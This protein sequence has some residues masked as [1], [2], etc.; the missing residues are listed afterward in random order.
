MLKKLLT[1]LLEPRHYWR[2]VGFSE[3]AELYANRLLRIVAVNMVSGVLGIFM[4][5]LGYELWSI[6]AFFTVYFFIRG[7][8]TIPSAYLIGRIGPKHGSLISNVLCIPALIA[9]TQLEHLGWSAL[10]FYAVV[11]SFCVSLYSIS[12]HVNF[13]KIKH[14]DHAGKELSFMYIIEKIGAGLSPLLGGI[15]AYLFG[16]EMTIWAASVVFLIAAGPLFLSPE[17]VMTHQKVI[18]RGLGIRRIWRQ[19]VSMNGIGADFMASTV[20]WSL[21]IA[22]AIFGTTSNI[23]YAQ[24]GGLM[25]I[26]FVASLLFSKIYGRIIDKSRGGE[27]LKISAVANSAIHL[28]RPFIATPLGIAGVNIVN[29]AATVGYAMPYLKGQYDM[30][31]NLPGYRIAYTALMEAA[32]CSGAA[33]FGAF[34]TLSVLL[35]G[36]VRG[37]Q[38]SY[39][40]LALF[41]LV[42]MVHR[43][44]AL[45]RA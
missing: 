5:Q 13:S 25:S 32:I 42:I 12:H 21:Y 22:I 1:R 43:F 24:I 18:F 3:L 39:V 6:F 7:L 36:D 19:L 16:P 30:A 10:I 40:F 9:L 11:Q 15:I 20:T 2:T 34:A 23:V 14:N 28:I 41:V 38:L 8:W 17:P 29:E 27:L 35:I 45:R 26:A 37:M 31:D 33:L 4:F 44:P